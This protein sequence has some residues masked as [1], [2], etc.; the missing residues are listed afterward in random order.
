MSGFQSNLFSRDD[1]MFGVCEAIGED[2]GFNPLFLRIALGVSLLWNPV[3]VV[4][5]Y[6]L[7]G[8]AVASSRLIAPKRRVARP[9]EPVLVN[10][11]P[12]LAEEVTALEEVEEFA[13]AA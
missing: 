7:L 8:V 13:V 10:S 1:T 5:A 12:A 9:S 11:E 4:A 6:L 3:A 2:F